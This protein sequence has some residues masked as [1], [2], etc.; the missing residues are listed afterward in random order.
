LIHSVARVTE[1]AL[2]TVPQSCE[3]VCSWRVRIQIGD[4][5]AVTAPAQ[6]LLVDSL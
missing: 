1:K 6:R 5:Q 3:A 2:L 4:G